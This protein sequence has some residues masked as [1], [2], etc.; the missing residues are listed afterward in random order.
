[1]WQ[2]VNTKSLPCPRRGHAAHPL[3]HALWGRAGGWRLLLAVWA[4][5]CHRGLSQFLFLSLALHHQY[6]FVRKAVSVSFKCFWVL[7][8]IPCFKGFY[9][10]EQLCFPTYIFCSLKVSYLQTICLWN[11]SGCW[12]SWSLHKSSQASQYMQQTCMS[13]KR[14]CPGTTGYSLLKKLVFRKH[15]VTSF[16]NWRKAPKPFV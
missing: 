1:M 12:S 10:L 6:V 8:I 4:P 13:L 14:L 16:G 3:R 11:D 2:N 15:W 9:L 7:K 5:L